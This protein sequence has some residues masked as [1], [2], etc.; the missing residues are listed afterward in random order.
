M[1]QIYLKALRGA[2]HM[3]GCLFSF[4]EVEFLFSASPLSGLSHNHNV[5]DAAD[6]LKRD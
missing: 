3:A 2:T 5:P 1:L 6:W 4:L